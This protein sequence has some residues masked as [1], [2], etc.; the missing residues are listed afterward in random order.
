MPLFNTCALHISS[1][2]G[3]L[4]E[5]K[6]GRASGC[7]SPSVL[8][9]RRTPRCMEQK[10]Q[11]IFRSQFTISQCLLGARAFIDRSLCYPRFWS[12]PDVI[13]HHIL[14][15]H[16]QHTLFHFY[17]KKSPKIKALVS[18]DSLRLF[19]FPLSLQI[20]LAHLWTSSLDFSYFSSSCQLSSL[21]GTQSVLPPLSF[22]S[23]PTFQSLSPWMALESFLE[24]P[25]CPPPPPFFF[26]QLSEIKHLLSP[27]TEKMHAYHPWRTF[28]LQV[29]KIL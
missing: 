3:G 4:D 14:W 8:S 24:L 28:F 6:E 1:S 9:L 18:W 22:A 19:L 20:R 17:I 29:C 13:D 21:M 11:L 5:R 23:Y 26:T 12:W 16:I 25:V 27:A 7:S 15:V 10:P 2:R